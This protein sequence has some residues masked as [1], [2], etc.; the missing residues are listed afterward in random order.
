MDWAAMVM[1]MYRMWA[2]TR[3]YEVT[4]VDEMPGEEAGIKV[5]CYAGQHYP[6]FPASLLT[7]VLFFVL[8]VCVFVSVTGE[9]EI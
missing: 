9:I 4:V 5:L 3:D 6:F 8:L 7:I 2:Q 1:R